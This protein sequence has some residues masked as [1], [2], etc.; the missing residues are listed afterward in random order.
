MDNWNGF[1]E[2]L[3][4]ARVAMGASYVS[5]VQFH[6]PTGIARVVAIAGP[7]SQSL[8]RSL[9]TVR[10]LFPSFDVPGVTFHSSANDLARA[11][12]QEG[13]VVNAPV[14]E[15]AEGIIRRFIVSTSIRLGGFKYGFVCPVK[16]NGA[17]IGAV[18]FH[19]LKYLD[20]QQVEACTKLVN[21]MVLA[22]QNGRLTEALRHAADAE[23]P[24][25]A[26]EGEL[27]FANLLLDMKNKTAS[28]GTRRLALTPFEFNLLAYLVQRPNKTVP[29]G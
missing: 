13:R 29:L 17:V 23:R 5:L 3:G 24:G 27:R 28:A 21:D 14:E 1:N 16:A 2:V 4:Q 25:V 8:M 18:A 15:L 10:R 12:Y 19:T 22:W 26:T 11:A 7:Q 9:S 6:R 20:P